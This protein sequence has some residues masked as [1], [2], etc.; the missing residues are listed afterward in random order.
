MSASKVRVTLTRSP[1]GEKKVHHATLAALGLGKI[2]TSRVHADS[3]SFRG[4]VRKV[5][6]LV[7]LE[8]AEANAPLGADSYGRIRVGHGRAVARVI[9]QASASAAEAS[10]P[11]ADEAV[12][13]PPAVLEAG[14]VGSTP[15]AVVPETAAKPARKSRA[16]EVPTETG[17]TGDATEAPAGGTDAPSPKARRPRSTKEVKSSEPE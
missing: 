3:A 7:T 2:G 9:P 8:P 14:D 11:A 5:A 1:N 10:A 12:T 4:M 6:H 17:P 15:A 16:K 13:A